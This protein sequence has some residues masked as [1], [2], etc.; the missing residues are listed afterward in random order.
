MAIKTAKE[1]AMAAEAVAKNY[2]TLYV[3]GCFGAPLN[4]K[5]KARYTTNHSYNKDATRTAMIK[6][7]SSDTFG[8]DCVCLIKGLLWGWSGDTSKTYGGA[9][10]ASN[11]VPDIG[12]DAMI[13]KCSDVS[14][15]FSK[16]EVGE[17]V[18]CPGH[19]GIYIGNGLAVEC[20]P[21]W[22]NCVQITAC[23]CVKSGYNR[24]V[25]TKH[26]KLPYVTYTVEESAPVIKKG[27]TV[28]VKQGAKTYDGKK[29]ASFIY[30]RK[31]KVKEVK[32]DRVV[33]TYLG[34]VVAAV[35]MDNLTLV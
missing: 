1:L 11:N 19:I 15:D 32:G 14:T 7:A 2:K 25:W 13:K 21:S 35:H 9:K 18:W 27:D 4:D 12:A 24:R 26:G 20:T 23:N 10:Y 33:I 5:N 17:A 28:K 34:I 29:L 30:S 3:M 6:A 16:V 31:H 8:F 22:D